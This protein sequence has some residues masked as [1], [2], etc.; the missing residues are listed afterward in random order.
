MVHSILCLLSRPQP[1]IS[2]PK[3]PDV[4]TSNRRQ[5]PSSGF[6]EEKE[7][8]Q[9][10]GAGDFGSGKCTFTEFGVLG[11]GEAS[12]PPVSPVDYFVRAGDVMSCNVTSVTPEAR[13][14]DGGLLTTF[15]KSSTAVSEQ[16]TRGTFRTSTSTVRRT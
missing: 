8:I 11:M 2:N 12:V 4:A 10:C 5:H 14:H 16:E 13:Y 15:I 3:R 1:A 9:T 6:I 7:T